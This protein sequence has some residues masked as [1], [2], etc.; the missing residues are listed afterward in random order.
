MHALTDAELRSCVLAATRAPSI[1]NTQPWLFL[2]LP[3]GVE[4]HAD[5]AR[6]L[7]LL[8]P[9][10][11]ALHISL[12][13]AVFNLR[14]ALTRAGWEPQTDLL[15]DPRNPR[16]VATVRAG[17]PRPVDADDRELYVAVERRRSNRA[18]FDDLLPPVA[19]LDALRAAAPTPRRPF[20]EVVL[21][22]RPAVRSS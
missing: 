13:A 7:P 14:I 15:P 10:G 20:E 1:H 12:G 9:T 8:D 11:R 5:V 21:R 22:A 4:V 16:H 2:P 18:P 17:G 6:R 3:D 19:D